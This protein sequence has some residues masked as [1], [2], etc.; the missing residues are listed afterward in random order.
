MTFSI[1]FA[2][3]G[4]LVV[5]DAGRG[6]GGRKGSEDKERLNYL[7]L[8]GSNFLIGPFVDHFLDL[9]RSFVVL[10]ALGVVDAAV[11]AHAA[12]VGKEDFLGDVVLLAGQLF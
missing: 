12:E 5:A 11:A 7:Q 4:A 8:L 1:S 3:L 10:G 6:N 9:I 2:I